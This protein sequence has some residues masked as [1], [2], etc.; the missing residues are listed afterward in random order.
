MLIELKDMCHECLV[1][2][3]VLTGVNSLC[4]VY[5]C[6]FALF[7]VLV[8]TDEE[9]YEKILKACLFYG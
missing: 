8:M 7:F 1:L 2:W 6:Y 5:I 3:K 9:T 4:S